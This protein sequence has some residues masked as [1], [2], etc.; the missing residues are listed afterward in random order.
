[1]ETLTATIIK[2]LDTVLLTV[3]LLGSLL[4]TVFLLALVLAIWWGDN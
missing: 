2:A 4:C 3:N 1:M